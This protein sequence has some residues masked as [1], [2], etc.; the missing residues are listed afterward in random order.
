MSHFLSKLTELMGLPILAS[1][2]GAQVDD[3]ILYVHALMLALFLGWTAYFF[4]ALWRF[5][6]SVHP[7]ADYVGTTTHASSYIEVAVAVVEGVLLLGFAVPLWAASVDKFP[8]PKNSTVIRVVGRQFN[9]IARYPGTNGVFGKQDLKMLSSQNPM[10]LVAKDPVHKAEDPDG[11]DDVI[12][13]SSEMAVPVD[14]PVIIHLSSLDVIHSFKVVPLRVTQDANPGMSI[15]FH[16]V[17]TLTNT[18]QI[19]C[20]QLCGNGHYSMKGTFKVLSQPDYDAWLKS[21]SAAAPGAGSFE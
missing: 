17:P 5:R 21:K 18:Y 9:W 14:K 7:K 8:D 13:E 4:Y 6:K 16:F 19:Q 11:S 20:S 15:P 2:H 10:A 3:L 12:I 1:K